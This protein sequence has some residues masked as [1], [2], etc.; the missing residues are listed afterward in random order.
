MIR[1]LSWTDIEFLILAMRWTIALTALALAGGS[2]VGLI[3]AAS[4]ASHR[5][6]PQYLARGYVGPGPLIAC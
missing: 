4:G 5:A 3:V 2:V 1:E 6:L